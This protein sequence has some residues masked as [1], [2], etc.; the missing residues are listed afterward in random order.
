MILSRKGVESQTVS[1]S[2]KSPGKAGGVSDYRANLPKAGGSAAMR[3]GE[4]EVPEDQLGE[5]NAVGTNWSSW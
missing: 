3:R 5:I 2:C 4:T 1:D